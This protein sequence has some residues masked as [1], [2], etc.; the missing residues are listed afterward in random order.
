MNSAKPQPPKTDFPSLLQRYFCDYLRQQRNASPETVSSYRDTFRLFLQFSQDRFRKAP[1][2]LTLADLDA[3]QILAFLNALES[4]RHNCV[5]S[6]N[7]RL[8]TLRSFLRYAASQDPT[9]LASITRALAIPVKRFDRGPVPYVA[10]EEMTAL[11]NAPDRATWSGHRDRVM[12]ATMYNTGARVSEITRLN[13]EDL[14]FGPTTTLRVHGKGR[15]ERV[16]PLWK[17]T[18][19]QL[20]DWLGQIRTAIGCPLFPDRRGERLTRTGVRSRLNVA[21]GVARQTC[22][23]LRNRRV[24]PHHFRHSTG[25]HLL[26]SG[27]DI[28]VIALWLG[29]EST[30]TTHMYV[31]ADLA[32]KKKA[33]DKIAMPTGKSRKFK[34]SD[35][36]LAFLESL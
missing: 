26:Q 31:E 1:A 29:H 34:P 25:M 22:P 36:L 19:H 24:S 21:L 6:R 17:S 13:V 32:M 33:I 3:P 23:T 16:I 10:R 18:R 20:Q 28:T 30:A 7:L 11:L 9:A 8:A 12:L 15:K 35:R 27:V 14:Q 4:Q 2:S 5:R